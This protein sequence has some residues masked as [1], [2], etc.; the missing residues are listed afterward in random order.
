M[1]LFRLVA[2]PAVAPWLCT[3]P[4]HYVL[5]PAPLS[6]T[7]LRIHSFHLPAS[8]HRAAKENISALHY[9]RETHAKI[10]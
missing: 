6:L 2:L 10:G 1:M 3:G 4:P 5:P 9:A 8:L 7:P